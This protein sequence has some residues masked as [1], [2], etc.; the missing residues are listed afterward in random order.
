MKDYINII[1]DKKIQLLLIIIITWLAYAN[2]LQNDFFLDDYQFMQWEGVENP[3]NILG[4]FQGDLPH[5]HVG[6]RPLKNVFFNL[7]FQ[8]FGWNPLGYH[9]QA[10]F[11]HLA[12]TI[13]VYLIIL[14]MTGRSL[15][16]FMTSLLFG[17]HPIHVEAVT[18]I[19]A[20]MDAIGIFFFFAAFY[21]YLLAARERETNKRVLY[22]LSILSASIGYFANEIS[23]TLPLLIILYDYCFAGLNWSNIWRKGRIYLLYFLGGGAYMLARLSTI[24]IMARGE[25]FA[26]SPYHTFLTMSKAIVKYIT[27]ILFP[28]TLNINQELPGGI[29]S[30]HF[31]ERQINIILSQSIFDFSILASLLLL[32]VLISLTIFYRKKQLFVFFFVGWFFISLLPVL[33]II[34]NIVIICER[35]AYISSL[36]GCFLISLVIKNIYRLSQKKRRRYTYAMTALILFI[37]IFSFFTFKTIERNG[38]WR[39]EEIFYKKTVELVPN[40]AYANYF[41]GFA[42]QR[43]GEYEKSMKYYQKSAECNPILIRAYSAMDS[44]YPNRKGYQQSLKYYQ[45]ALAEQPNSPVLHYQLA[46]LYMSKNNANDAIPHYS[47]AIELAPQVSLYHLRLGEAYFHKGRYTESF[48]QFKITVQHD[49][50]FAAAYEGMGGILFIQGD[51]Q[52]AIR[53]LSKSLQLRPNRPVAQQLLEQ[54]YHH[55]N[56]TKNQS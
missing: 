8:V 9:L 7:S 46:R 19:T 2:I 14:Q 38:D 24:K 34:P 6:Y 56:N 50:K 26:N 20:S 29:L 43:Q 3:K 17:V 37:F 49:N 13:L 51:F 21:L 28:T 52:N 5:G 25:F 4:L 40:S 31:A 35:Y 27:L 1:K 55:L 22:S 44:I 18:W 11:F 45:E 10:I 53:L 47:R 48:T 36:A 23:L 32:T 15:L 42:L 54:T 39:N 41:L 12:C 30:M 16:S 33:N